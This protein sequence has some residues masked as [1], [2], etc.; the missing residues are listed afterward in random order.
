MIGFFP[1]FYEDELLYSLLARY[2]TRSGYL[3]YTYAAEDLF[4]EQNVTA[5]IEFITFL[6]ED[7]WKRMY[8]T[9]SMEEIVLK[10]T[11][12]PYYTRFFSKKDKELAFLAIR[13]KRTD[14]YNYLKLPYNRTEKYLRFCPVCAEKDRQ[15]LGET[16]WHRSHQMTGID[17]CPFH[18]CNLINSKVT[19]SQRRSKILRTAESE[20]IGTEEVS[21]CNNEIKNIFSEYLHNI[22]QADMKMEQETDLKGFLLSK[23]EGSKFLSGR[24]ERI[25]LKTLYDNYA[26]YYEKTI[27]EQYTQFWKVKKI[28]EGTRRNGFEICL[29][30]FFLNISTND[31]LKMEVPEVS[32]KEHFD[33][34]VKKL[35]EK[36][37]SYKE[38]ARRM[39]VSVPT[40]K[41]ALKEKERPVRDYALRKGL[42]VKDWKKEDDK[43]LPI[44][45]ETVK[46]LYEGTEGNKPRKVTKRK[47]EKILGLPKGRLDLLK[48]CEQEIL[49]YQE[50]QEEYWSRE[51]IWSVQYLMKKEEPINFYRIMLLTNITRD[52]LKSCYPKLKEKADEETDVL[53]GEMIK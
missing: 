49:K 13:E 17:V 34:E 45:K 51:V 33:R 8:K 52:N 19:I 11:M 47:V 15:E 40:I 42:T 3:N 9:K 5:E 20:I 39:N 14:Y 16:Y 25:Y 38:I 26:M 46:E 53:I 6:K 32:Q 35:Y 30:A 2:Y 50:T 37:I 7:I 29:L 28:M 41:V 4:K 18:K 44:V 23:L 12:F 22:F 1:E 48:K 36:G 31:L 21:Y 43:M 10:H 27:E 24:G